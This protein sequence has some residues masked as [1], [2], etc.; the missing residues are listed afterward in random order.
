GYLESLFL[1]FSN[2]LVFCFIPRLRDINS[3]STS[4]NFFSAAFSVSRYSFRAFNASISVCNFSSS[5]LMLSGFP[6]PRPSINPVGQCSLYFCNH[7]YTLLYGIR[8][9]S[10]VSLYDNSLAKQSLTIFTFS[11]C[12]TFLLFIAYTS[13]F[14]EYVFNPSPLVYIIIHLR[15]VS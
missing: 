15:T 2:G 7:E 3:L 5:V 11:S 12:V 14:G 13:G 1:K 6:R 10:A 8:Y 9:F 4:F